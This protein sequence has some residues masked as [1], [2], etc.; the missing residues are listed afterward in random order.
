MSILVLCNIGN[1]DL[2]ADGNRPRRPRPD[3]A[4]LWEDRA[5]H[6][7]EL[8]IIE[9]CLQWLL[10]QALV[11]LEI[12]LFYTDQ[13]ANAQTEATDRYGVSL[14]D[15][16]TLWYAQII[17]HVLHE[18]FGSQISAIHR[19]KVARSDGQTI[20]PSLYDE[21][22][23]AYGS[24]VAQIYD[25]EVS[26]CY[27]MMAGG[28]PACNIAL[29]IHTL[30]AF[31]DRSRFLYQPEGGPPYD[32]RVG[33]QIQATFR[34]A[35]ALDALDRRDFA[36]A[37]RS[38]EQLDP[39]Q[40]AVLALL[41]YACYREAFDFTRARSALAEGIRQASGELRSFMMGIQPDLERLARSNDTGALLCE[42][43]ANAVITFGNQRYADFLGRVFRFQEAALRHIVET[44]LNLPTN[45]AKP[46]RETNLAR[47]L[48]A[49]AANPTL[50]AHLDAATIDGNPLV[51]K[52]GPNRPV[53]S[54]LLDFLARGG[55]RA[56][57][58]PYLAKAEQG[59]F[60]GLKK[61][62]D[63]LDS[64]AELRNQSII[65]HGYAGVSREELDRAYGSDAAGILR[66]MSKIIELAGIGAAPSTF[67]AIAA[68]A[69][70]QLRRGG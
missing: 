61:A 59:R 49:I 25:P 22:F 36:T 39:P 57:G 7:F 52:Y 31:G 34:R 38:V 55:L 3:G 42:V 69:A 51:Y 54:S 6:R 32:L 48:A 4:T 5:A 24:L 14:R 21:A 10:A 50:Q 65:A 43:Y 19:M 58:K 56:D 9:P 68:T 64:L 12:V 20:N 27:V 44:Q 41:R 11:P 35:T 67:D 28:I 63:K 62:M 66:D 30:S 53:M 8:P 60:I 15:K 1:S 2:S 23:D 33:S 47:F 37:L 46:V 16:D 70:E 45:L 13:P 17:E 18:R 40:H 26:A 29:Q